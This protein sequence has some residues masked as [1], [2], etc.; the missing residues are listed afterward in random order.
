[1]PGRSPR[2]DLRI[3]ASCAALLFSSACVMGGTVT[4]PSRAS[5]VIGHDEI[6]VSTAANAYEL[7]YQLR[8]NWLRGRGPQNLRGMSPALPVVYVAH[9]RQGSVEVLRGLATTTLL[10]LRYVDATTATTR[11]GEGHSG[12]VIEVDLRRR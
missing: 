9:V 12:G 6:E 1:M 3:L 5:S 4:P 11:Y 2:R 8:P 10:E 7:V